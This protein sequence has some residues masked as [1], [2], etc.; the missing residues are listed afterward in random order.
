MQRICFSLLFLAFSVLAVY[1]QNGM[2]R[3]LL[4]SK[5][6]REANWNSASAYGPVKSI[7]FE[8]FTVRNDSGVEVADRKQY[9]EDISFS[10]ESIEVTIFPG[11]QEPFRK[12]SY[13]FDKK[14]RLVRQELFELNG[15]ETGTKSSYSY[16][17]V[18]KL[19]TIEHFLLGERSYEEEFNHVNS[20]R[21][22][23]I[24]DFLRPDSFDKEIFLFNKSGV[25]TD[26]LFPDGDSV[27]SSRYKYDKY[28][29]PIEWSEYDAKG[30]LFQKETYRLE[31][32][33]HNNWIRQITFEHGIGRKAKSIKAMQIST[34]SITY[35]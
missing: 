23:V 3:E 35:R 27:H 34:R 24:R 11:G 12:I 8:S 5:V 22:E 17:Q 20:G 32:D 14:R 30:K 10:N 28:G 2:T 16:D 6:T 7:R 31:Y 4:L 33:S 26:I 19:S 18:G 13:Y 15:N 29:N 9:R 1:S 25:I 21:I